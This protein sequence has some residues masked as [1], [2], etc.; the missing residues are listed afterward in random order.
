MNLKKISIFLLGFTSGLP[1]MLVFV[2]LGTWLAV[3]DIDLAT[4]GFFA[5][6]VLTYSL[7][8]LWSPL[9]DNF[10][11]PFLNIFGKRKSWIILTQVLIIIF[12]FLISITDP[13]TNLSLFAKLAFFVA[14]FGSIQD[15][16]IDAFRIEMSEIKEQ[17][18]LAASYQLGYRIAI[19][20]ATSGALILA[21][22][23]D[24]SFVYQLM[25]LFM[26]VGFVGLY[27]TP[28]NK[29]TSLRQLSLSDSI[30][31]PLK[32]FFNRFGLYAAL[33]LLSIIST[34]R[35]TDIMTGQIINP[36]YIQMGYTLEEIG[37]VVKTIA[38]G[39]SILG[40][41]V[42]G[43][44]IKS[45]GVNNSLIIGALLVMITN[46]FFAYIA[47]SEKS[48][49]S[50]SLVVA[51]DSMAAGIVG[52]V[53]ITFLTSLVSKQYTAVQYALFTSFMML[54]GK[55][56]AGFSGLIIIKLG[57]LFGDDYGWMSFF[58]ITS[59]LTIPSIFLIKFYKKL[60]E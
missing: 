8:F 5:W 47:I 22:K 42:G 43:K 54:P 53:N 16:A 29:N 10:S 18:N 31:V 36:F 59:A 20:L 23:T 58:I 55:I 32:D 15:I 38:L 2:T 44:L 12:L 60:Y 4:I 30:F 11:I 52:T 25:S 1:Y 17:G 14:F 26:L 24:W 34:Y 57:L 35:L 37:F 27:L 9:V 6:I 13:L 3:I 7:K 50:L 40:F 49:A 45:T 56:L 41:F 51:L 39:A 48:L 46:L 19:L 21:S 28:E 33:L